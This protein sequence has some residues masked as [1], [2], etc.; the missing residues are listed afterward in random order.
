M[1]AQSLLGTPFGRKTPALA[2]SLAASANNISMIII[3]GLMRDLPAARPSK[4]DESLLQRLPVAAN[5]VFNHYD[6]QAEPLCLAGMIWFICE[7]TL[8][9]N[10]LISS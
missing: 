1:A 7:V 3:S 6:R 2:V 10:K 4:E 5:A 9:V 8:F